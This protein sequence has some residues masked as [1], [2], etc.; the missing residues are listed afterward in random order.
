[1][2]PRSKPIRKTKRREL[3]LL[4][5]PFCGHPALTETKMWEAIEW[6]E[7]QC[8]CIH[9]LVYQ[10]SYLSMEDAVRKWNTRFC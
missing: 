6:F 1:M 3:T 4:A 5:C 7:V 9:C 8:T 2:K 10:S